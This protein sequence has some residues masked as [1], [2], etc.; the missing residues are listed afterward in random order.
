MRLIWSILALQK[1]LHNPWTMLALELLHV[2]TS[3]I[4]VAKE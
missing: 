4:N 2:F 1:E 3:L